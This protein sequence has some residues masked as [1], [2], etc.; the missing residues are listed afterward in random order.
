MSQ[1]KAP[2][3]NGFVAG[4]AALL[5]EDGVGVFEFP[6]VRDLI[7]HCE[8]DTIY[9]EHLCYYSVTTLVALFARH[10]LSL[11]DLQRLPIHGGSLRIHVEPHADVHAPVEELLAGERRLGLDGFGYYAAFGER[12]RGVRTEIRRLL[13]GLKDEGARI[14]AYGAAAK[15]TTLLNYCGIGAETLDFVVDR[16]VHKHGRFMPGVHLPISPPEK[17]LEEMPDHVLLLPWNFRDEILGQQEEYRRRGG[18]FI[19]PIPWPEVV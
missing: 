12:V 15:G 13:S 17:L 5:R 4:V 8:F 14:A 18:R 10:G 16:N 9:H 11:N 6:Y 2:D 7:E 1:A 19:V 3:T